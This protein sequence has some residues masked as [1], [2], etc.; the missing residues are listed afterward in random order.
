MGLL[1]FLWWVGTAQ[2]TCRQQVS[3]SQHVGVCD[4]MTL[5]VTLAC[6]ACGVALGLWGG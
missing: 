6:D 2:C 1:S 4:G 5:P 3:Q